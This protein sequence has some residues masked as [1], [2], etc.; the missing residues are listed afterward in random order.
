MQN[1]G[2]TPILR[3]ECKKSGLGH[4]LRKEGTGGAEGWVGGLLEV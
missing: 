3:L 2:L 1:I 4:F